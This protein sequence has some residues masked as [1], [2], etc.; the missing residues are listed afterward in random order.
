MPRQLLDQQGCFED[1]FRSHL[2]AF[3]SYT[4]PDMLAHLNF[5]GSEG[6]NMHHPVQ[7]VANFVTSCTRAML[8]HIHIL[9]IGPW[10]T[11]ASLSFFTAALMG[12]DLLALRGALLMAYIFN[13]INGLT[14]VPTW[15]YVDW[16]GRVNVSRT[17]G[18]H[19]DSF[20]LRMCCTVVQILLSRMS[21]ETHTWHLKK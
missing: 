8:H 6:Y 11:L 15:P 9:H 10:A 21:Q 17:A 1:G 13:L 18:T 14:G 4:Q 20:S 5:V 16:E 2:Q 7:A 3:G 19:V 12:G